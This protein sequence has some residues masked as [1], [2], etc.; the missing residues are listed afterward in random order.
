MDQVFAGPVRTS[1]DAP[2]PSHERTH[3]PDARPRASRRVAQSR[4]SMDAKVEHDARVTGEIVRAVQA[5]TSRPPA[6]VRTV[7]GEPPLTD[8]AV[9]GEGAVTDGA[10]GVRLLPMSPLPNVV[11]ITI[12]LVDEFADQYRRCAS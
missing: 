8:G 11:D 7:K 6:P 9:D 12:N 10:T 1:S 3:S 4:A 2:L 5:P